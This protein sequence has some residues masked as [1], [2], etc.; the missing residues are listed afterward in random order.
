MRNSQIGDIWVLYHAVLVIYHL[1]NSSWDVTIIEIEVNTGYEIE[2]VVNRQVVRPTN[3]RTDR[4]QDSRGGRQ[5]DRQRET[6]SSVLALDGESPWPLSDILP[7]AV[8]TYTQASTMIQ[9][10]YTQICF[11]SWIFNYACNHSLGAKH[12]WRRN[13]GPSLLFMGRIWWVR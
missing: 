8:E 11:M 6:G 10:S 13:S 9:V 7:W 12:T 1:L 5:R 3:K 4:L 2:Y